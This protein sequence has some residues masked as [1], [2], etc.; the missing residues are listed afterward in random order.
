MDVVNISRSRRFL[1]ERPMHVNLFD[2]PRLVVDLLCLE[3]EQEESRRAFDRSDTLLLI[4]EGEARMRV[5]HQVEALQPMDAVLVA[6]GLEYVIT[7]TGASQLTAVVILTPKPTRADE[8]RVPGDTRP[9]RTVRP[10]REEDGERPRGERPRD[11]RPRRDD[12]P[13]FRPADRG[14]APSGG[15]R[16]FRA[17]PAP[18]R[19]P[20]P[21]RDDANARPPYPR[22]DDA[23]A[24][25]PYPRRD[26]GGRPSFPRSNNGGDRPRYP[27]REEGA[28]S[29]ASDERSGPRRGTT[30]AR[31]PRRNEGAGPV[32]FPKAK[33]A[34]RPRGAPPAATGRGRPAPTRGTAPRREGAGP[35]AAGG[36]PPARTGGPGGGRT[37]GYRPGGAPGGRSGGGSEKK[38]GD[39]RRASRGQ[40]PLSGRRGPGRSGPRT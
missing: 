28:P 18:E 22:R 29:A 4:T 14:G 10:D 5:G 25:P 26:G 20:Y 9:F 19:R 27:R 6:P 3:P 36:R 31:P 16:P 40:G 37:G 23:N 12:R 24:R 34:W 7:N 32:W 2:R 13:A 17:G 35:S 8:V 30:G 21:R 39:A 38:T 33:P 15:G 1:R 11:E